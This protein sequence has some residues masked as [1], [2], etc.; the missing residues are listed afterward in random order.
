MT[1]RTQFSRN[2]QRFQLVTFDVTGTLLEFKT[3]PEI[4]YAKTAATFG[5]K[6]IDHK[7]LGSCFRKEFKKMS[8]KYPNFGYATDLSWQ[9]WWIQLVRNIFY[10]VD[11]S[12]LPKDLTVIAKTLFHQYRSDGNECW[13][14]VKGAK[15]L[16]EKIKKEGKI[17]GVISN[18]D[19]SLER[20]LVSLNLT[21][22]DFVLTS[23]N[24][25]VEKPDKRIFQIALEK[26]KNNESEAVH[27]GNIVD[28]DYIGAK[29]AGWSS[30]LLSN[31]LKALP[32][33]SRHHIFPNIS[34]LLN[35]LETKDIKW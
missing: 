34:E 31:D 28:I 22:F 29:N 32:K 18:F 4:Q 9:Q 6:D 15:E 16:I 17:I 7:L 12:I 1:L 27:V 14:V 19:P 5:L 24:C 8:Q 30:I 25:G 33:N 26:F 35:T 3:P 11:A 2:L 23:Y 10:C 13:K 21:D 20:I